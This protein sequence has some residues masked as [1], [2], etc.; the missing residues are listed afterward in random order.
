MFMSVPQFGGWGCVV[1][2]AMH[3]GTALHAVMASQHEV[4]VHVSH[5]DGV[6]MTDEQLK[7]PASFSPA[8]GVPPSGGLHEAGGG[9]FMTVKQE[10]FE[11]GVEGALQSAVPDMLPP[12]PEDEELEEELDELEEELDTR[13]DEL[14]VV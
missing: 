1:R 10:P 11:G 14:E 4:S 7:A 3:P 6:E 8:S 13:P 12:M 5:A 2:Q 9:C